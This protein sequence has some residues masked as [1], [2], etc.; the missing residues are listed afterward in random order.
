MKTARGLLVNHW[1][2]KIPRFQKVTGD[3]EDISTVK[4][5]TWEQA[6]AGIEN[7]PDVNRWETEGLMRK[8]ALEREKA[9]AISDLR[10]LLGARRLQDTED[11]GFM[12]ALEIPLPIFDRNQG[13]ISEARLNCRKTPY[14]KKAAVML[15]TAQLYQAY[16]SLAVAQ[17][18]VKL[19]NTEV[20]P[21]AKAACMA[22]KGG[23][24]TDIQFL[25]AQRT[26]FRV[27]VRQIDALEVFH[28]SLADVE[29]LT[30]QA[31]GDLTAG[32]RRPDAPGK[33]K[34]KDKAPE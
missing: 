28:V 20:I 13:S 1:D 6:A 29:R 17:R 21:A 33:E 14:E 26:L 27:R 16:Q 11:Y 34:P 32:A 8:A 10:V 31:I 12:I 4:I 25:K 23:G 19:L 18:E 22:L 2:G 7:N 30:G 9:N 15:A 5:P 24:L 3:L